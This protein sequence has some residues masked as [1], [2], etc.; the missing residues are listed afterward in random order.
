[1]LD[2]PLAPLFDG[3]RT[4]LRRFLTDT[5]QTRVYTSL[6][7]YPDGR[8]FYVGKGSGTRVLDHELEALRQSNVGKSNP[9]KC[10]TIRKIVSSGQ[11]VRYQI[12][13]L[14]PSEA[15]MECL[16]REEALIA[17]F[18]RRC[19]GGCLTNLAAGLGSL[20]ARDPFSAERHAATLSG[21]PEDQPER[22]AL[23]LFLASLGAVD[24]VPIKPLSEYRH[25]LVSAYPSPKNLKTPS[26]RNGLTL[27]ASAVACGLPIRSGQVI[28]RVFTLYPE[29]ESWPLAAPPPERIEAVIENGA[30]SDVLKLGLVSL[31]AA[32]RPE[33][34]AFGIDSRQTAALIALIGRSVL[35][36]WDL[37]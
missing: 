5:A 10:N 9:F 18:R 37:L 26:R 16:K 3:D 29:F 15:E 13:R 24:S 33:D 19:D 20:S 36:E 1:M 11:A 14:F 4:T 23:N 12:D 22:A 8:P 30:A 2:T 28:P 7:M 34:E 25:R 32:P 31:I 35:E 27:L 6:L 17:H 21:L